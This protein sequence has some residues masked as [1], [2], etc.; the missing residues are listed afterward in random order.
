MGR[1][2]R[3]RPLHARLQG[4][5]PVSMVD[6]PPAQRRDLVAED[7]YEKQK[8]SVRKV[9]TDRRRDVADV[10]RII[11]ESHSEKLGG[12]WPLFGLSSTLVAAPGTTTCPMPNLPDVIVSANGT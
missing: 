1:Y 6:V 4:G 3:K 8:E 10:E 7:L 2:R 12:K 11:G 5:P 9:C